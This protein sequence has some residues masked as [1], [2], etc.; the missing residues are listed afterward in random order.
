V[1]IRDILE[2]YRRLARVKLD[3]VADPS[4]A[5]PLEQNIKVGDPSKLQSLG[6]RTKYELGDTLS[7]ILDYWRD[8]S[9]T[10]S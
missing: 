3:V 6:W 10:R 7:S 9:P 1:A 5:R 4:L 2:T 8:V